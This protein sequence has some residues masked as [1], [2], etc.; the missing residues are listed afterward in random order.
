MMLLGG[1]IWGTVAK[2][3]VGL[4]VAVMA[5]GGVY[6]WGHHKGYDEAHTACQAAT[7]GQALAAQ[8]RLYSDL[9]KQYAAQQAVIASLNA[10]AAAEDA[11][12]TTLQGQI[13]ATVPVNKACDIG[14]KTIRLINSARTR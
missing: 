2:Y 6:L 1:G 3:V 13:D 11:K 12:I 7:L 9:Q 14:P 10:G 5:I 4:L 8:K